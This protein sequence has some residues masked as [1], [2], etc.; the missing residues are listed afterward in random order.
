MVNN[1]TPERAQITLQVINEYFRGGP[2]VDL[3]PITL[4]FLGKLS[5]SK[6]LL[7]DF[8]GNHPA[9][10]VTETGQKDERPLPEIK[11]AAR[12]DGVYLDMPAL[13]AIAEEVSKAAVRGDNE[14]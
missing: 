5:Y 7:S 14:R 4:D 9:L 11:E 12:Y 1:M 13:Q 8:R 6:V 2:K 3:L 10:L